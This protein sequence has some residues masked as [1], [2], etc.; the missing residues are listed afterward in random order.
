VR[1]YLVVAH[2]TLVDQHLLDE[3]Q[4]LA[5]QEPSRFHLIV[6]MRAPAVQTWSDGSV[7]AATKARLEE[8]LQ[9]MHELGLEA[10]GEVGDGHPVE[11][12]MQFLRRREMDVDEVILSTLP[13]GPSR[14]LRW[15]VPHRLAE[16]ISPIPMHH[17]MISRTPART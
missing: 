6:P 17:V 2:R 14:W 11:A 13:A 5:Q 1:T 16:A 9:R 8:G 7:R 3:L 12:V 10:D 15:D 4:A